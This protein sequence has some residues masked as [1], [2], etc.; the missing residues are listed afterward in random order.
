M[1]ERKLVSAKKIT[2][3][4][5]GNWLL[6][7]LILQFCCTIILKVIT[8]S[9]DSNLFKAII[10]IILQIITVFFIWKI[11]TA[12]AFKGKIILEEDITNIMK[13]LRV[14][15]IIICIVIAIYNFSRIDMA[16]DEVL[17]TNYQ[18]QI[19]E[20]IIMQIYDEEQIQ[21][22]YEIKEQAVEEARS[23]MYLYMAVFQSILTVIHLVMLS[24]EKK[25]LLNY[26]VLV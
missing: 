12:K 20:N 15:I 9:I 3:E 6:W 5:I 18:L 19:S 23:Q 13:S 25:E 14:F 21:K 26:T 10:T 1:E 7:G 8:K 11:S 17:K 4:L 2:Q 24:F 16:I 22:Y